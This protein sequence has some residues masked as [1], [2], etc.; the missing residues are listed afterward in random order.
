[1]NTYNLKSHMCIFRQTLRIG[2]PLMLT[3][4]LKRLAKTTCSRAQAHPVSSGVFLNRVY[5]FSSNRITLAA[6]LVTTLFATASYADVHYVAN[7]GDCLSGIVNAHYPGATGHYF[8]AR[9]NPELEDP[10][11]IEVGQTIRLPG[12]APT[13]LLTEIDQTGCN[14]NSL[15]RRSEVKKTIVQK[16][17][18]VAAV[19][20][21]RSDQVP[22]P[23]EPDSDEGNDAPAISPTVELTAPLARVA[24]VIAGEAAAEA[25]SQAVRPTALEKPAD[26]PPTPVQSAAART[27]AGTVA[28]P[29]DVSQRTVPV[30]ARGRPTRSIAPM[31]SA[32]RFAVDEQTNTTAYRQST[33]NRYVVNAIGARTTSATTALVQHPDQHF[34]VESRTKRMDALS[35]HALER[36]RVL[37]A[38]VEDP[39]ANANTPLEE[40]LAQR[41]ESKTHR[42]GN[43]FIDESLLLKAAAKSGGNP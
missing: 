23:V 4:T 2:W 28:V 38:P 22:A 8:V 34:Y 14:A 33:P 10:N 43:I 12:L 1:M 16:A 3:N 37:P 29:I 19:K 41:E 17:V 26:T 32:P 7:R 27:T 24:S 30:E 18:T 6:A 40:A 42:A 13:Q 20:T 36:H 5:R 31:P 21:P 35:G 25:V 15:A 11:H 39:A 9:A